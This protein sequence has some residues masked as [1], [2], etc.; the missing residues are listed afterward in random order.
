MRSTLL[1]I[2]LVLVTVPIILSFAKARIEKQKYRVIKKEQEFEIRFY[3]PAIFATTRSSAKSYREL[4]NSGFRKIAGYIFGNNETSAKI[5]MTSPVHMDINNKESSM[6]F[7][8]PSEYSLDKLPR[9]SD[10]R[11]VVH[12]SPAVYMAA[13]EFSGYA[14]DQKIKLYADKLL[15]E[16]NKKGIKTMGNPK[17]LGYNAPYE[18]IGRKNEVVVTIEWKE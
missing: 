6:S 10:D 1:L 16:V 2:T 12:E 4:G 3:P 11:V 9:P 7:V 5:A 13:I 17:Y 15:E 18:F 14:N 8:M